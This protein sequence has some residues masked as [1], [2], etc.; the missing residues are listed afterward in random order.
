MQRTIMAALAVLAA[1]SA[2][3]GDL[4]SKKAPVPPTFQ[5]A[6]EVEST[7]GYFGVI[8]GGAVGTDRAYTGGVV[9]GYNYSQYL[10]AEY[11]YD[12]VRPNSNVSGRDTKHQVGVNLLPKYRLGNTPFT[13]YALGGVGYSFDEKTKNGTTYSYGGGVKYDVAKNI[14]LDA[15]IKRVDF[16]SDSANRAKADDRF[17]L[18]INFK[19]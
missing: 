1:G 12:Y 19:F 17:T 7:G 18:G 6:T 11:G 16:F 5:R 4:P 15:R 14:E 2:L 13:V 8:G 10:A 9:A 3:A